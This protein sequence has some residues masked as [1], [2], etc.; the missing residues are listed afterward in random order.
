MMMLKINLKMMGMM[1]AR[2]KNKPEQPPE[3]TPAPDSRKDDLDSM[4][5]DQSPDRPR[6][7]G[8]RGTPKAELIAQLDE[9]TAYKAAHETF[10]PLT[11]ADMEM[12]TRAI[13][14]LLEGTTRLPFM[15][16]K[17]EYHAGFN[18]SA[19][20]CINIY[21]PEHLNKWVP[22][23]QLGNFAGLIVLDA[24]AQ[25]RQE[26]QEAK[27]TTLPEKTTDAQPS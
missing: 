11:A 18:D 4:P 20:R 7:G 25:R 14:M 17:P 10:Q 21:L 24:L 19:A 22:L 1:M 27:R 2:T 3:S 12:T 26:I 5:T 23:M 8:R 13:W 9:L 16:V 6:R 15:K